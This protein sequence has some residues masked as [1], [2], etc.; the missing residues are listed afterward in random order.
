M[1][2]KSILRLLVLVVFFLNSSYFLPSQQ[3]R[4]NRYSKENLRKIRQKWLK[5]FP[6][7]EDA[8]ELEKLKSFLSKELIEKGGF[9]WKPLGITPLPNGNII[10]NDQKAHHILMFDDY[11]YLI[12]KIGKNG[13]GPGEFVNDKS[14]PRMSFVTF[15]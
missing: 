9:L 8:I 10:V 15:I 4:I 1:N 12:R 11:G 3:Q 6:V 13:Q 14:N 7:A 5:K 2:L